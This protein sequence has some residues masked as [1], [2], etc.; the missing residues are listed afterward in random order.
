MDFG[1]VRGLDGERWRE[2]GA[3]DQ[4]PAAPVGGHLAD[5]RSNGVE[6][7][8]HRQQRQPARE[9]RRLERAAHRPDRQDDVLARVV[10][11]AAIVFE[12]V[13][14]AGADREAAGTCGDEDEEAVALGVRALAGEPGDRECSV[15]KGDDDVHVLAHRRRREL[16]QLLR[17]KGS[18]RDEADSAPSRMGE[19][20]GIGRRRSARDVGLSDE[21]D[22]DRVELALL[23]LEPR[24]EHDGQELGEHG[25]LDAGARLLAREALAQHGN[26][27]R[28]E[29]VRRRRA[30]VRSFL[31]GRRIH[32]P[33]L[34]TGRT[35][36][37]HEPDGLRLAEAPSAMS[38]RPLARARRENPS[39][40]PHG[41]LRAV[42]ELDETLA[43]AL[44]EAA[45]DGL[46]VVDE[47]GHIVFVNVQAERMFGHARGE[48]IGRSIE[49]LF[50]E[51]AKLR[52][53]TSRPGF[54]AT[55]DVSPVA[56][57]LGLSGRRSDGSEF[58]VDV[59][60]SPVRTPAG[61]F[62]AASVRD[63]T[64]RRAV[65]QTLR[66]AA[67]HF[68]VAL[69]EAPIGMA[70]VALDG[71]FLRVNK[72][73]CRILRYTTEELGAL[74]FQAIVHPADLDTHLA[75]AAK[76][77]RGGFRRYRHHERCL[78][79]DG[80]VVDVAISGSI[81]RDVAGR[82]LHFIA[83]VEDVGAA[84]RAREALERSEARLRNLFD[85]ASDGIFV[86]DLDGH[87]LDVNPAACAMLGYS[88]EELAQKT[89]FDVILPEDRQRIARSKEQ[90]LALGHTEVSEWTLRRRDGSLVPVEAS[91]KVLSDGRWEGIARDISQRRRAEAALR[92]S[93]DA[94]NRAQ[95]V[96]RIGSWEWELG[97]SELR[98]SRQFYALFGLTPRPEFERLG[99][100]ASYIHPDDR[101]EVTRVV[102]DALDAG[103]A[104]SL[105]HRIIRSDGEERVVRQQGEP[106]LVGGRP[107]RMVGTVLDITDLRRAE[108]DR[109]A[110]LRWFRA[111]F[112]QCPVGII[113][114]RG[115]GG[116]KVEMNRQA[117][118]L[119]GRR[120]DRAALM[121]D[122]VLGADERPI[123]VDDLPGM[124]RGEHVEDV[125]LFFRRPDGHLVP[126]LASAAPLLDSTGA[127]D[128]AVVAI[129]DVTVP[130][131]LERL[132][133]EWSSIVA[134]DLR[135]PLNAVSLSSQ[136][137]LRSTKNDPQLRGLTERILASSKRL[138]RMIRDLMDLSRLEAARLDLAREPVD[139][140][141]LVQAS[142]AEVALD[143]TSPQVMLRGGGDLPRVLGDADRL[144]QVMANLLSNA[145]KY[146]RAGA[147]IVV[148]IGSRASEVEIAVTNEGEG[149]SPASL[150]RLFQRFER[151]EHA[152]QS[153][154]KGVGLGLH[155]A[156]GL[157][158][159]HGGH[160]VVESTPGATTTFRFTLPLA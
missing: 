153:A 37:A 84:K 114:V 12:H 28:R 90:L 116:D 131:Q 109:E 100:F 143:A 99:A 96:G 146:G 160:L 56:G 26:E 157:V 67:E 88:R 25:V 8:G 156:R 17:R 110:S 23:A 18:T 32:A 135:Q 155:I 86:A 115:T 53:S 71:R 66:E 120:I 38:L 150:P 41:R 89:V 130:R 102:N 36:H 13:P 10:D 54:T 1:G 24:E 3:E 106:V 77:V 15:A 14:A 97:R 105:E 108:H 142:I 42:R 59:S 45:P 52:D 121:Q 124:R 134:H 159:A 48:L 149:I 44:A 31:I 94:L 103:R 132:R 34:C 152:G 138:D 119:L 91:M 7:R 118:L 127:I 29:D 81:V 16:H 5:E 79:K 65:E 133:A 49:L 11:A 74:T 139:L 123:A 39:P 98:R 68:R 30:D 104:F 57:G 111:V 47:R 113:L 147:P 40:E 126:V 9:R 125:E 33:S 62:L 35:R 95:S 82:A 76:L 145:I 85:Q 21:H 69:D 129:Q 137:L 144:M 107:V 141:C 78:R 43:V 51:R 50:P 87:Y 75:L 148:D 55:A 4:D 60:V 72:A 64:A 122:L 63:A 22:A 19:L 136:L 92:A 61:L 128:G 80:T 70:F 20:G 158:E 46:V 83:Q 27:R 93:E 151:A 154:V 112:D 6:V 140:L 58:P 101:A 2:L 73:L 117:E